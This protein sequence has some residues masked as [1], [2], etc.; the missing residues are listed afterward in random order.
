[1]NKKVQA[2]QIRPLNTNQQK[3]TTRNNIKSSLS[4]YTKQPPR[5]KELGEKGETLD[6]LNLQVVQMDGDYLQGETSEPLD[7]PDRHSC[8][9]A[10][11]YNHWK[12]DNSFL[13]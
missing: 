3:K 13:L 12:P 5:N 9:K 2:S 11:E 6:S 8:N 10:T 4:F 1:M 7:I